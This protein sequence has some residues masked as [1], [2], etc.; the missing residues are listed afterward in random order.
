MRID[1]RTFGADRLVA[2]LHDVPE[3][4]HRN[5]VKAT[6]VTAHHIR[7]TARERSSGIAHAPLYPYTISYD[8]NDRG[9]GDGV[10]AEIG[11]DRDKVIGGGPKRTPGHLDNIFEYGTPNSAPIPHVNPALDKWAPDF[12]RGLRIAAEQALER[13]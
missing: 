4:A 6:Q 3:G 12:E 5:V 9:V 11:P 10:D 13:L 8:V 7:D 1:V 2:E